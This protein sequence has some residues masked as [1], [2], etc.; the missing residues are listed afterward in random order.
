MDVF[1]GD[2]VVDEAVREGIE[3][4]IKA[5]SDQVDEK[6]VG[7]L[8]VPYTTA[9]AI[10][11]V[12]KM[13]ELATLEHDGDL[14]K[15]HSLER[16]TPDGEPY[17]SSIDSWARGTVAVKKVV[18][19]EGFNIQHARSND[20][21]SVSSSHTYRSKQSKGSTSSKRSGGRLGT[22]GSSMGTDLD[23]T[24]RIIELDEDLDGD[25]ANLSATGFMF[26]ML[27]K[28][29]RKKD[30]SYVGE[31]E[32]EKGE[33]TLLQEQMEKAQ[34]DLRG[35]KFVLD[36]YG[37]PVVVGSVNA[38]KLTPFT[39]HPVMNVKTPQSG[40]RPGSGAQDSTADAQQHHRHHEQQH[41][42]QQ[43]Q[44]R[45]GSG[46]GNA[47]TTGADKGAEKSKPKQFVRVA[48]SRGVE[49]SSFK[50]TL[51]LATALAGVDHIPKVNPGVTVRSNFNK[52][53]K[54]G[55]KLP[56]DPVRISRKQYMAKTN[57]R[58]QSSNTSV[59]GDSIGSFSRT[60]D[61]TMFSQ[62]LGADG[63]GAGGGGGGSVGSI[64]SAGGGSHA[65][66]GG[67]SSAGSVA[68]GRSIELLPD[69]DNFEGSRRVAFND[70]VQDASD[71]E[72]GLGP[73]ETYGRPQ[74]SNLP[75]KPDSKQRANID[76]L[77]GSP[78]NGRPKDRDLPKNIRPVSDRRHLPAPAVG[79]VAG[80][81]MTFEKLQESKDH[82][83]PHP[84]DW[85]MTW[86]K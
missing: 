77:T 7:T 78:N 57:A 82:R 86:K 17:P 79:K 3:D 45:R 6:F 50:P 53:S 76:L 12:N 52:A 44:K 33:F 73:A 63:L 15:G 48:G 65:L 84:D 24:G 85:Y 72:L 67:G 27:Q 71:E 29:K 55:E 30:P 34:H 61:S 4:I 47:P 36:R 10:L 56:D 70:T 39:T 1:G 35:K 13:M 31:K 83:N 26:N 32:E 64:N 43:Q 60:M 54:T 14:V 49:E 2:D 22:G 69:M 51:S 21:P 23:A 46:N 42:Q 5:F 74:M 28:N 38:D 81:G 41:Q 9:L 20:T 16:L 59:G 18:V 11:K 37:Q 40:R 25:F 19:D 66:D 62:H 75:K 80:H 68:T 8:D 58:L